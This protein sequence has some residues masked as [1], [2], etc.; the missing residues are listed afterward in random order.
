MVD[1]F[2]RDAGILGGAFLLL[3]VDIGNEGKFTLEDGSY[4]VTLGHNVI[5]QHVLAV[6]NPEAFLQHLEVFRI[7]GHRLVGKHVDAG[8]QSLLDVF[9]LLEVVASS[10]H[11]VCLAVRNHL[12]EEIRACVDYFIPRSGIV[13]PGVVSLD[14]CEMFLQVRTRV[15]I[16][17]HILANLGI[18]C[19][20]D[21][22]S[23]EVARI[24]G[25]DDHL[26][27]SFLFLFA[28]TGHKYDC[29]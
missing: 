29:K 10:H 15:G 20:L 5:Q 22:S 24:E 13:R 25:G 8:F 26:L 14:L 6:C 23:V 27:R 21:E 28:G 7:D 2:H 16:D 12:L 4:L 3:A 1:A 9:R 19:F 11:Y 17:I 18:G